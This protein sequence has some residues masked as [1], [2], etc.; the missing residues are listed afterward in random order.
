MD[1]QQRKIAE[2][3]QRM[4]IVMRRKKWENGSKFKTYYFLKQIEK[5]RVLLQKSGAVK[6]QQRKLLLLLN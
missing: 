5:G 1:S 2:H 6:K 4:K 3:I